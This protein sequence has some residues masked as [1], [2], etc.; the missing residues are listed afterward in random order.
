MA[1]PVEVLTDPKGKGRQNSYED[2]MSAHRNSYDDKMA[3][4]NSFEAKL[5][6]RQNS[7]EDKIKGRQNSFEDKGN[8]GGRTWRDGSVELPDDDSIRQRKNSQ[9]SGSVS[10]GG[11]IRGSTRS[12]QPSSPYAGL[13]TLDNIPDDPDAPV[14]PSLKPPPPAPSSQIA[15]DAQGR[16]VARKRRSSSIK[17]KPS[18]GVTPTKA[19]DWEI[20]RKSLHSS[21]GESSHAGGTLRH[22]VSDG[23]LTVSGFLTLLLNHWNPPTVAPLLNILIT[24]LV[25]V[26][27]ADLIRLQFPAFAE[28]WESYVGFLMRET[29]RQRIN[30]VVWYLIGVIFVLGV[31]PRDVAVVS[32]LT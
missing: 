12:P 7:Y 2:K 26:V 4:A 5:K 31:Y 17:R 15:V 1:D 13:R 14:S 9:R 27:T 16:P 32:I 20:P 22:H 23:A 18:P 25:G 3:R 21:I 10:S 19:V 28:V 6:G 29:E 24:G 11:S 8:G 30:G